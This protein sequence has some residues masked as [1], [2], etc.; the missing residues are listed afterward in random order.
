[1]K[2]GAGILIIAPRKRRALLL[3]RSPRVDSPGLW[4]TPGGLRDLE[5]ARPWDTAR[6]EFT[7]ETG[8]PAP[9]SYNTVFRTRSPNHEYMTFVIYATRWC[10]AKPLPAATL[11]WE[12]DKGAWLT[13]EEAQKLPL[14]P[15][16]AHIL[17]TFRW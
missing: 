2:Q 1:M 13:H 4:S 3:R 7:E 8:I 6:R 12:N 10:G 17:R 5:D 9:E 15:G 14:H 16:L 11:N